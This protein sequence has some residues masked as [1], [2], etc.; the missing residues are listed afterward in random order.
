MILHG[1]IAGSLSFAHIHELATTEGQTRWKGWMYPLSVDLLMVA[2][3]SRLRRAR[4]PVT[5]PLGCGLVPP[6]ARRLIWW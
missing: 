6:G 1:L 3:W 2:A 4:I 5:L